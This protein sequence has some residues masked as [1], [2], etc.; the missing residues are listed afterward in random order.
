MTNDK[1]KKVLICGEPDS[2]VESLLVEDVKKAGVTTI[3]GIMIDKVVEAVKEHHPDAVLIKFSPYSTYDIVES[4]ISRE[5]KNIRE[6]APDTRIIIIGGHYNVERIADDMRGTIDAVTN[7]A[8][9]NITNA[10]RNVV[11]GHGVTESKPG[12]Q[13]GA[14]EQIDTTRSDRE[15][16]I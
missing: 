8:P 13:A 15:A 3:R 14:V 6:V 11:F 10:V 16:Y 2:L 4:A 1:K 7:D 12:A 5:I 9:I